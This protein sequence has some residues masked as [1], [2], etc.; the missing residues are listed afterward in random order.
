MKCESVVD[1]KFVIHVKCLLNEI[2]TNL[3]EQKKKKKKQK[4]KKETNIY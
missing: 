2:F 3:Y 1:V 4:Q